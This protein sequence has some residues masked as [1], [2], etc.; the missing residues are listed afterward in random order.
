MLGRT[1]KIHFVGIGGIG[2]SGI[3]EFLHNQGFVISG[4]DLHR[5]EVTNHLE[6]IGISIHEGHCSELIKDLDVVVMSSAVKKDNPEIATALQKH[7]PVIR[8]AEMLAEIMRMSYGIA[9]AGTHG[10]TTTTSLVGLLLKEADL[11]PTVIVGGKVKNFGSNNVM[12]SGKYIIVE[13]DE[14]D[15]SFLSLTPII[16]GITNIE[17]DHLDCYSNLDDIKKAFIEYANRVPFFGCIVACLDDRGVQSILPSLN[18]RVVTYGLSNQADVRADNITMK[19]SFNPQCNNTQVHPNNDPCLFYSEFDISFEKKP[20][21]RVKL[22][23]PGIHNIQNALQAIAI[24]LELEVGFDVIKRGLESFS[25]VYRRFE[26]KGIV[27]DIVVYDDYAHHPTEII[28]TLKGV[29]ESTNRR[30]VAVFQ[31]H[32]YSRTK[33][34]CEDFGQS[35]FFCDVLIIT[36]IYPAREKPVP[37]VTGKM[38]AEAAVN[39]GHKEVN[40]IDN[41]ED[42]VT[43]VTS[44]IRKGDFVITLGAGNIYQFGEKIIEAL[45]GN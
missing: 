18:K 6:E 14:F 41:N 29:K 40:Y 20:L 4:S 31:P 13:A 42:I 5:T 33:D 7:I 27:D 39:A 26:K 36:P 10:K 8:R 15:R 12:G 44:I 35:F 9:I 43:E 25:G 34:F 22:N 2:M 17:A 19:N 37:G 30:I 16:A 38:I 1:K 23:A 28:A 24:A 45:R 21:G 3:A 11:D 32:L